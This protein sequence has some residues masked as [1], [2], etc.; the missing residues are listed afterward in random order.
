[1]INFFKEKLVLRSKSKYSALFEYLKTYIIIILILC[2]GT[3]LI[4]G[5]L[6]QSLKNQIINVNNVLLQNTL[7]SIEKEFANM[8]QLISL[9]NS[10][11]RVVSYLNMSQNVKPNAESYNAYEVIKDLNTYVYSN[12]FVKGINI[13]LI[14]KQ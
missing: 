7:S 2:I 5:L 11:P 3:G 12:K 9:V 13:F 1:M 8:N 4:Y 10:N 14:M 6:T